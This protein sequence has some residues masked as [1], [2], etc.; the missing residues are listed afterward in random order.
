[1]IVPMPTSMAQN[2]SISE[3]NASDSPNAS[4]NTIRAAQLGCWRTKSS[5]KLVYSAKPMR[6][7]SA[8]QRGQARPRGRAGCQRKV[9]GQSCGRAPF[10]GL[11]GG[12]TG[13]G[14]APAC[15]LPLWLCFWFPFGKWPVLGSL[16]GVSWVSRHRVGGRAVA[17]RWLALFLLALANLA[18]IAIV[19][20]GFSSLTDIIAPLTGHLI[21]IGLAAS[22][23]PAGAATDADGPGRGRGR[24]HRPCMSGSACRAAVRRA[25]PLAPRRPADPD[26]R[27]R[28]RQTLTVLSLNT[29]HQHVRPRRN[30]SDYLATAPA[31]VVVLSEFGPDRRAAAR[32]A[33]ADLSLPG[34][35]RRRVGLLAG[36][37]VAPAVRGVRLGASWASRGDMPAF[38]WAARRVADDHRHPPAPA[39]PRSLAARAADV[40]AGA[41]RAPH[42]RAARAGRRPQHLALVERRSASCGARRGWCRPAS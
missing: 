16:A 23:R 36:A 26:R 25:C 4:A 38:V 9:Q 10:H 6:S 31:D 33:E 20:G 3:T 24:H 8:P 39:E 5:T 18:L 29:W 15:F 17:G 35:L 14:T 19:A 40:G 12:S 30:W 11:S 37:A 28:S 41:V 22:R 21:G 32:Q 7:P 2:G 1:M 13:S 27:Q 42:R 34:R